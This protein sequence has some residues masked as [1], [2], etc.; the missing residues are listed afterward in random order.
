MVDAKNVNFHQKPN[1]TVT[2]KNCLR[3]NVAGHNCDTQCSAEQL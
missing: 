3:V 1:Q 2:Y